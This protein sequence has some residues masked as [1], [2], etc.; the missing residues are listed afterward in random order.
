VTGS[1]L[2]AWIAIPVV[3][4]VGAAVALAGSSGGAVV[5]GIP[6]FAAA[7]AVIYLVQWITFVPAFLLKSER[8]FDLT[9]SLTYIAVTTAAFLLSPVRDARSLVLL[10]FVVV[11]AA[12]L[13]TFL[14]GRVRRAGKDSR[15]DE[16]KPSF[17]RFLLVWTL[18]GLWITCT[19]AAALAAMTSLTRPGFGVPAAIG[20]VVWVTGFAFEVVADSQKKRFRSD[21]ANRGRFIRSGLWSRS[22]H[23]NYFGEIVLWT[24]AAIVALPA[25]RGAALVTLISPVFVA[26]LLTKI[27]GIPLLEKQS[28]ERW[29]ADPD[30]EAYKRSTPV[31]VPKAAFPKKGRQST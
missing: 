15:F 3:V 24:G 30:Y 5:S 21:P 11:W 25:L 17:P 18:Q 22:R 14:F 20:A 27:S 6:L 7:V 2:K 1:D 26:L 28:D 4:A 12:R 19:L 8:F 23:P 31:L 13:G 10:A 29:G 16:L 9:G